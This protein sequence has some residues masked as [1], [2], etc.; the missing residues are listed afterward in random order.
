[1]ICYVMIWKST[2]VFKVEW[3]VSVGI[4]GQV[5]V[6]AWDR[7]VNRGLMVRGVFSRA[8]KSCVIER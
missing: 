7:L 5:S 4:A 3:Q 2:R 8:R 1:M 6:G